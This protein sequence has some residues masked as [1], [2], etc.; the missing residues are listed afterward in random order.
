M[1]FLFNY[2]TLLIYNLYLQLFIMSHTSDLSNFLPYIQQGFHLGLQPN[3]NPLCNDQPHVIQE[4]SMRLKYVLLLSLIFPY[5]YSSS[6]STSLLGH[7]LYSAD[8]ISA[9]HSFYFYLIVH[10]YI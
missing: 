5:L 6:V 10:R 7:V 9:M 3:L 2:Y 8:L 1:E 4:F